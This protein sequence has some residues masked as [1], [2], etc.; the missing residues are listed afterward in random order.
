MS[1]Q[2]KALFLTKKHGDWEVGTTEVPTPG[3]GQLLVKV[4][5]TA[6]NPLE[7]GIQVR[8]ILVEDYPAILGVDAAGTVEALGEGVADFAVGDRVLIEGSFINGKGTFQQYTLAEAVVSAKIPNNITFD[9]AASVPLG[10]ATAALALFDQGSAGLPPPWEESGKGRFAGKPFV[11]FGGATSVGQ[12]AIQLAKLS[13]FSP[14]IATASPSNAPY[15][16]T[17]GAT[18][19]LDR[20]LA[21]DALLSQITQLTSGVPVEIV[22]L[23]VQL[24]SLELP[25]SVLAPGGTLATVWP[26]IDD[27]KRAAAPGKKVAGVYGSA[28]TKA[29]RETGH[30]LYRSIP[31]LLASGELKPNRVENLA[32]GL[33][34]IAAGLKKMEKGE[35][36]GVKLVV[37]PQETL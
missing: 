30:S 6:L 3:P 5:A 35:V 22:F 14:I 26:V 27:A 15:L 37:R 13:G 7:V 20:A 17:L 32:D 24:P 1:A 36:S 10:L 34:G 21:P 11:L 25:V 29:T 2:Q 31:R 16:H 8:G 9:Q 18:H 33:K 19:V 23:T 12:Y 4:E 28:N